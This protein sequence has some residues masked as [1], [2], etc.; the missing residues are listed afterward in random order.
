MGNDF[1]SV[2]HIM[3]LGE[4]VFC[5]YFHIKYEMAKAIAYMKWKGFR[6]DLVYTLESDEYERIIVFYQDERFVP[7]LDAVD[8][9]YRSLSES[10]IWEKSDGM[11]YDYKYRVISKGVICV[12]FIP[13][14]NAT[15]NEVPG[16]LKKE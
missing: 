4:T 15:T 8:T 16:K 14:E 10:N 3:D 12:S 6:C 7:D 2:N 13:I 9:F 1:I 5:V 11:N